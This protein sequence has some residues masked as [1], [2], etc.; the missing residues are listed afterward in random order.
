MIDDADLRTCLG[1]LAQARQ[2][3]TDDPVRQ[4]LLRAVDGLVKDHKKQRSRERHRETQAADR[5]L[6]AATSLGATDR[7][8]DVT[9]EAEGSAGTLKRQ[10]HCYICKQPYVELDA[11][12]QWLCP[13]CARDNRARRDARADLPGRRALITGGRVKIGFQVARMLLRDGAEVIVTTR[14]PVDAARRFAAEP[15]VPLDRLRIV[16]VDL[17]DPRQV[18]G[19]AEKLQGPLDIL[20]NNAAQTVKRPSWSYRQL[21]AAESEPLR[22]PV[23]ID[24]A[25]GF[26]PALPEPDWTRALTTA[27]EMA[28]VLAPVDAS[29][30]VPDP[31][32]VNSW[33]ARVGSV[34]AA[35]MLEVQL[36]NAVAPF[37][38]V[39]G[40]LPRLRLS[41]FPRRYIVNVSAVEGWFTA[42]FKSG[43]HPH[44][45]M[46]KAALNML[47][48]TSATELAAE[49]IYLT[50]VDTGWITDE[51]PAPAK[52]TI[53]DTGW[54]PPLDVRDGAARIYDP[55]VRG[56]AGDPPSGVF[57]KDYREVP[58]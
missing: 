13:E 40:L 41:S 46:A 4:R 43:G 48:R 23:A 58:W 54:R 27:T 50:S 16:G 2:L 39:D 47:T 12:Y 30:L 7:T 19:L 45:N 53:A 37:L 51:N 18:L 1:V 24:A 33:T 28:E 55:I 8:E 25:P 22:V 29:G 35:E 49:G 42:R 11:F 14:F 31:S 3:P 17:R 20:I 36:I 9:V 57:L 32:A 56:E 15:D 34:D 38:L 5:A 44:T 26:I 10:K 21:L 6:L 52:A